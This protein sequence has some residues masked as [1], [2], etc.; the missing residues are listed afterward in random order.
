MI[1]HSTLTFTQFG[2]IGI[3]KPH[4]LENRLQQRG[5]RGVTSIACRHVRENNAWC[6]K[7]AEGQ[8][9]E[10][11]S[12]YYRGEKQFGRSRAVHPMKESW[13]HWL[14]VSIQHA[15]SKQ[16]FF[17]FHNGTEMYLSIAYIW[18]ES[19]LVA[20]IFE[21][22]LNIAHTSWNKDNAKLGDESNFSWEFLKR[23]F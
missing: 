12:I 9:E 22:V 13:A 7:R 5:M 23:M 11:A 6:A 21:K 4:F 17:R 3:A 15:D 1:P 2:S 19:S 8:R 20:Y 14:P 10:I 16:V 18:K